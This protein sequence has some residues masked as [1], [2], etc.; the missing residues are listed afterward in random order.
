MLLSVNSESYN[1]PVRLDINNNQKSNK[2]QFEKKTNLVFQGTQSVVD[3]SL[4]ENKNS[5]SQYLLKASR[6]AK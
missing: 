6:H 2:K 3:A 5:S 4:R 1:I